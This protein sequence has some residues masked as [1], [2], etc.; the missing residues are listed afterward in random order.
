VLGSLGPSRSVATDG[1]AEVLTLAEAVTL[2]IR[3][4]GPPDHGSGS[5][6]G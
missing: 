6:R 3:A 4:S 5:S 1:E 2:R